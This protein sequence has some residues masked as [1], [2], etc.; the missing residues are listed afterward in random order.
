M[1]VQVNQL[2]TRHE[3]IYFSYLDGDLVLGEGSA[4]EELVDTVNGQEPCDVGT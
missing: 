4:P 3:W 2:Y 1:K